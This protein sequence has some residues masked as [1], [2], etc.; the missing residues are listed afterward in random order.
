MVFVPGG[1][2]QM[3][4][5]AD[6]TDPSTMNETPEHPV[7]VD[8]FWIDKY[9]IDNK[10][11]AEFLFLRGNQREDGVTWY[12]DEN[13]YSLL[14]N[15]ITIYK[16]YL[17]FEHHPA[18]NISWYGAQ[19]YCDWIGGRLLTEAEWE[20][21]ASGPENRVYPWG[22][23]YDCTKGNFQN[24]NDEEEPPS[25]PGEGGCDGFDFTSPVDAYPEGAS[26]TGVLDLA[27]NV[28]D[29]VADW[30]VSPYPG[31]FQTNPAG[32][33]SGTMKIVRGGSWDDYSWGVRTTT[34]KEYNPTERSPF[35]GFRCAYSALP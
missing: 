23:E 25:S 1:T 17:G 32:P 21:A 12:D 31:G 33:E 13:E 18:I 34:R 7:Q 4:S 20:Y 5:N 9:P 8:S 11:F 10:K 6:Q 14:E 24:W 35:I 19:A 30:G 22:N 2:F 15:R 26:W 3:G 29:W 27:G 28:G 16:P